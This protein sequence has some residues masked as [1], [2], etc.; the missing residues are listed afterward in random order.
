MMFAALTMAAYKFG[1]R[2]QWVESGHSP[3]FVIPANAGT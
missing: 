2:P 3:F 1:E